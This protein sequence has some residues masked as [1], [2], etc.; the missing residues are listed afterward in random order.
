MISYY[1]TG[2]IFIVILMLF[3][4]R[5]KASKLELKN[6][7]YQIKLYDLQME[8]KGLKEDAKA[9]EEFKSSI[10]SNDRDD[11]IKRLHEQGAYKQH[12]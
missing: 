11:L 12:S 6:Q 4:F 5:N 8:I 7:E 10:N 9:W 1:L 2:A 3:Y